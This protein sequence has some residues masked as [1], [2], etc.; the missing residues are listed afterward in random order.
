M[1]FVCLFVG[2]PLEAPQYT[3]RSTRDGNDPNIVVVVSGWCTVL[4]F[5]V[6]V[7]L[8]QWLFVVEFEYRASVCGLL[9]CSFRGRNNGNDGFVRE[10]IISVILVV[11]VAIQHHTIAPQGLHGRLYGLDQC[12]RESFQFVIPK[13]LTRRPIHYGKDVLNKIRVIIVIHDAFTGRGGFGRV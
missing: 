4:C 9:L 8:W 12:L 5:V 11:V 7:V 10:C 2:S 3:P 13:G 1:D 6:V